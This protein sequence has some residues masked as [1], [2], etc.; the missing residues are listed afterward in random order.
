MNEQ[1]KKLNEISKNMYKYFEYYVIN[2]KNITNGKEIEI[3][4]DIKNMINDLFN[5]YID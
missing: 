3:L 2:K 4:Q 5:I 1:E